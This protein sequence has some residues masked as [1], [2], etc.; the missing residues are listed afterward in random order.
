MTREERVRISLYELKNTYCCPRDD[1][2]VPRKHGAAARPSTYK[3]VFYNTWSRRGKDR[4]WIDARWVEKAKEIAEKRAQQ[5][6]AKKKGQ[7]LC[8]T[9]RTR[10]RG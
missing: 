6:K 7:Q 5:R 10:K 9:R 8:R 3:E 2:G 1:R 4:A